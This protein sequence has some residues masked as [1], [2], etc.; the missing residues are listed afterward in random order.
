MS[1]VGPRTSAGAWLQSLPD[2]PTEI[3]YVARKPT[4]TLVVE[5]Q[6]FVLYWDALPTP[7]TVLQ[8][9]YGQFMPG[10]LVVKED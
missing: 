2:G 3:D 5:W 7:K 10:A 1:G 9:D 8:D 4:E 6:E